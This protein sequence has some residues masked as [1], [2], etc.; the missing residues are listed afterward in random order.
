MKDIDGQEIKVGDVVLDTWD[1]K[2]RVVRQL[3]EIMVEQFG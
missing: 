3:D 2:V 1:N